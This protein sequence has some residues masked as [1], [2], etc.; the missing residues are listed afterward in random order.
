MVIV[1]TYLI[2]LASLAF[3]FVIDGDYGML[4]IGIGGGSGL[5]PCA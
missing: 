2:L 3:S 1:I 5:V 4:S